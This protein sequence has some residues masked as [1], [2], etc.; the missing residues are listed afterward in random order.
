LTLDSL[1]IPGEPDL[2]VYKYKD[3]SCVFSCV[4]AIQEFMKEPELYIMGVME[5]CRKHPELIYFLRMEDAFKNVNKGKF[6]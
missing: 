4:E 5:Q 1:L 3:K 6:R 2:G